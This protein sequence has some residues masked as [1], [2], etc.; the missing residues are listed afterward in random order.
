MME[1]VGVI[2][3]LFTLMENFDG[4]FFSRV[5]SEVPAPS[6]SGGY[7]STLIRILTIDD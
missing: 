2:T 4:S 7:V 3:S 1:I 6:V 5:I